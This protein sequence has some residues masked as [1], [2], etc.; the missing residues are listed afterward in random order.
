MKSKNLLRYKFDTFMGKGGISIFLSLLLVFLGIFIIIALL[1]GLLVWFTPLEMQHDL[2]FFGNCY[3]TFLELT[4]PGNMAQDINSSIWYKVTA[5]IAGMAG[6]IMLSSLIAFITTAL[7]QKLNELKRGHSK[8]IEKDHTL[9]LGWDDQR[10]VEIIKELVMANESEKDACVVILAD[11]DKEEMDDLIKLRLKDTITTR[12]VTRSGNTSSLANLDIVSVE[13]CKSMIVL[14]SCD[15]MGSDEEKVASDAKVIQTILAL[16]SIKKDEEEAS[17]VAEIFNPAH[18]RIIENSFPNQVVIVD[19]G[20]I[21]AKLLVQTSRSVGLSV[22]YSEILSFDGCEMYFYHDEWD[23]ITF[24]KLGYHFP[25]GV[26]MG[27]RHKDGSLSLNPDI[28]YVL[29]D[30]DEI[31]ILADDDS[32]IEFLKEPVAKPHVVTLA[33][34]DRVEQLVEKELI[35]GWTYKGPTILEQYADYVKEGSQIDILIKNPS[36]KARKQI[37]EM[38]EKLDTITIRLIEKDRLNLDDLMSL[39]PFTYN[40]IIILA[41]GGSDTDA[42]SVDSENLVTLLL[43]RDIFHK[44]PEESKNTKLIT[45]VLD[46]QNHHLISNAGVKDVIISNQ[47]VS[48]ILAQLSES[49]KIKDVYDD[50]FEE[51]GSEIYLKPTTLYFDSFPVD[52]TFATLMDLTQQREEVCLG[53]KIKADEQDADKNF[54]VDLIPE[55]N[56]IITLCERDSLVVLSEDEF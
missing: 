34:E 9:I 11:K 45:E 23:G 33:G 26:P 16:T 50:I 4:D 28:S 29:K 17:I 46:S 19:T 6:V 35:L 27:V 1:R 56:S 12:I 53:I 3:I 14:A 10:I 47:L 40:N 44:H 32:T 13:E 49:S 21:L 31:L 52:V 2:G 15:D 54:G 22:V 7:D 48:M 18:R 24:Q 5:V 30:D 37:S 8:V 20:D 39:E 41:E 25:D 38:N 51:D 42:H 43:L 36:G 55:K